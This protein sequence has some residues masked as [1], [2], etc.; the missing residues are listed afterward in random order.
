MTIRQGWTVQAIEALHLD[1]VEADRGNI[2]TSCSEKT[3]TDHPR[4]SSILPFLGGWLECAKRDQCP[5]DP[6][7]RIG[8]QK[9]QHFCDGFGFH[10]L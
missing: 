9:E 2:A 3:M 10:P 8:R 4:D 7:C 1:A 6:A 5:I